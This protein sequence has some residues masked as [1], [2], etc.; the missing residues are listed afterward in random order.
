MPAFAFDALDL[1]GRP[2]RGIVEADTE[3]AV[4]NQLRAQSLVPLSVK[5]VA[6]GAGTGRGWAL[7]AGRG[8]ALGPGALTLWTRQL[9]DMVC[10]GLPLEPALAALAEDL[11]DERQRALVAALRAEVNGGSSL[12]RALALHPR[13]FSAI[14]RAV[15]HAG[16]QSG[17]LGLVLDRLARDLAEHQALRGK[18]LAAVLYP[19]IVTLLALGIVGF[20][21]GY[22]VPHVAQVY[23]GRQHALPVLTALMLGLSA[24]LRQHGPWLLAGLLLT[25]PAARAALRV[26][27]VREG[28]D[29]WWLRLPLAGSFNAARFASTLGLLAGAGVPIL[30][31]MQAAADTLGNA[32]MRAGGRRAVTQV[33][34]GA[35]LA[36]AL[37]GERGFPNVVTR[38]SRLGEQ[39]GALP[40]MLQRA[41]ALLSD[42][43]QRRALQ[44]AT[45]LEP[46]LIVGMGLVVMLI[47]LAVLLP[48]IE[49]NQWAG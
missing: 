17:Q 32:A 36:A 3:R 14:Y 2:R 49:L 44:M 40:L 35:S 15:V 41:A 11:D 39:T 38:F 13:E 26:Q 8:R 29:A 1:E 46:L 18:V 23:A 24:G 28:F 27:R 12:A 4:R 30:D 10:A 37:A 21:L 9:A 48:I 7:L 31:A 42:D 43:V 33:R 34:E 47:V 20:L 22:V 16:E 25:V 19:A 45:I 5:A 6:S